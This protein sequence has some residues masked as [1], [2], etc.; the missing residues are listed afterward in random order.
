MRMKSEK[1]L[2]KKKLKITEKS[3]PPTVK[4]RRYKKCTNC[5]GINNILKSVRKMKMSRGKL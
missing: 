1:N 3:M 2:Q 4:A 5:Y